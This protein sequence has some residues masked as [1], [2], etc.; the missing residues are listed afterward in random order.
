MTRPITFLSDYGSEDDFVG[1]CHAVMARI[2]PASRIV[3]LSHGITRQDV[4]GG[5]I[6]LRRALPYCAPGVHVAVV[7]PDVGGE[8]RAIALRTADED[9]VL[10]GPD[11]GLLS[12][13]ARRFG[14]AIEAVD[15]G[16]S[17]H[18]LEP[19]SAT[20][21][22]RDIFTPVAAALAAG[23]HLRDAGEPID[24]DEIVELDMP[25]A[26][27]EADEIVAHAVAID[28]FGN[29]VLDVE[30]DEIAAFGLRLGHP[31]SVSGIASFYATT[32]TDAPPGDLLLYEDAYRT[33]A[34]AV[35]RGS[36]AD[37]LGVAVG[38]EVRIRPGA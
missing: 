7:D 9:R 3:D 19:V 22:G 12:L 11:N 35:N 25:L 1:V 28:R 15:I 20:F 4:R 30:H 26:R 8:R 14:G 6:V 2:A 23:A 27:A 36:A 29:V 17:P 10:V 18:R 38:D 37:R 32:F 21:H 24:P 31:V 5:A 16:R 13:A 34:L 33:L